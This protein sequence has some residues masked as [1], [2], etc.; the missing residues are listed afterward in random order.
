[1][2]LLPLFFFLDNPPL[3]AFC[4]YF[5]HLPLCYLTP[6]RSK[7]KKKISELF[8]LGSHLFLYLFNF[9]YYFTMMVEVLVFFWGG[10]GGGGG[11]E[12][13][14]NFFFLCFFL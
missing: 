3:A 13:K 6:G 14:R 1:M 4:W 7:K 2:V 5:F 12:K 8:C 10:G 9:T 11:R